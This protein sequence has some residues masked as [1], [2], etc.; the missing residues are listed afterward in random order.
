MR[1][2][3][4]TIA[5]EGEKSNKAEEPETAK[6]DE[7]ETAKTD[8]EE[9]NALRNTE[10]ESPTKP[11]EDGQAYEQGNSIN[12]YEDSYFSNKIE[13]E[14]INNLQGQHGPS[15]CALTSLE[16]ILRDFDIEPP[17]PFDLAQAMNYDPIGGARIFDIPNALEQL[18]IDGIN[19][20]SGPMT[21]DQLKSSIDGGDKAIVS[22][23]NGQ[24]AH[25]VIVDGINNG[26]VTI[27]DPLPIGEGSTYTV[28]Q[29]V[30]ESSWG[31]FEGGNGKVVIFK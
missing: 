5:N 6:S 8:E 25:A 16:M 21:I 7:P 13:A 29:S 24:G 22:V 1:D 30:F 12:L 23:N 20:E 31:R 15:D 4:T 9:G 28:P 3:E 2:I 18:G 11:D 26:N 27:R 17:A 14:T 19:V 10:S